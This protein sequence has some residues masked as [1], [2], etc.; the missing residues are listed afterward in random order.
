LYQSEDEEASC[1]NR[2]NTFPKIPEKFLN[3]V[4]GVFGP[5]AFIIIIHRRKDVVITGMEI[6]RA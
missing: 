6:S 3:K 4:C 2:S 1:T 5:G